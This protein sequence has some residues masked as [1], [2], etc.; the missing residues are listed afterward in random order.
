VE[1]LLV[2]ALR[3][4]I[5]IGEFWDMTPRETVLVIEAAAW[6]AEQAQRGRAWLAWHVAA[7]S[8]ATRLPPL[9]RLFR[10]PGAKRLEGEDLEKRRREFEGMKQKFEKLTRK[11][12]G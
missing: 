10:L 9:S 11:G 6:R 1:Q 8:R 7:L 2:E 3:A 5:P 4:G 12:G